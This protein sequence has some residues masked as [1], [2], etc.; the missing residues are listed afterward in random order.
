ME[1]CKSIW[2]CR[3]VLSFQLDPFSQQR[4]LHWV[5]NHLFVS[6]H[7]Y[8]FKAGKYFKLKDIGIS[9]FIRFVWQIKY[10]F[11]H[12]ISSL[13]SIEFPWSRKCHAQKLRLRS[14]KTC[15][16]QKVSSSIADK[17]WPS[18]KKK[19]YKDTNNQYPRQTWGNFFF[20]IYNV[21][22]ILLHLYDKKTA[23]RGIEESRLR[24]LNHKEILK[25]LIR[26]P[27]GLYKISKTD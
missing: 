19:M 17:K 2:F 6:N 9:F 20:L 10:W 27:N 12:H 24:V 4:I 22:V 7:I 13:R 16:R 1:S 15:I 14:A 18:S 26:E 21:Y 11:K 25:D 8:Q 3:A 5:C 23:I